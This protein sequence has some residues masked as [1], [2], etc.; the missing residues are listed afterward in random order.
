MSVGYLLIAFV[1]PAGIGGGDVKLA[2][3]IG[4]TLGLMGVEPTLVGT[5]CA[6]FLSA[7]FGLPL[8]ASQKAGRKT[9]MPFGPFMF[10]GAIVGLLAGDP[11]LHGYLAWAGV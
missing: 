6:F 4:L 1:Y 9:P 7:I 11:V 5:F 2:P 10:L 8:V 3:Y